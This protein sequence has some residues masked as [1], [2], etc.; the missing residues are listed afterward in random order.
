[1]LLS[2]VKSIQERDIAK[3]FVGQKCRIRPDAYPDHVYDGVVSRMMPI[4]DRAKGAVSVRV[5]VEIPKK[6]EEEQ[7]KGRWLKPEMG[8]IVSFLKK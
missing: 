2:L 7:K 8:V 5:K 6:E 3:V 1:M 4:A